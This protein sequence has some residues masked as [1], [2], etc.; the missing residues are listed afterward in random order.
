MAENKFSRIQLRRG[1]KANLKLINPM[2]KEGEP[3]SEI[4]TGRMKIGDGINRYN[5]LKYVGGG[6]GS[7]TPSIVSFT[8]TKATTNTGDVYNSSLIP[9]GCTI[10][11]LVL[12]YSISASPDNIKI[13]S[14]SEEYLNE[15]Y[16][17]NLTGN[18]TISDVD[19]S[20]DTTFKLTLVTDDTSVSANTI[21]NFTSYY[22]FT[23]I[24]SD[25]LPFLDTSRNDSDMTEYSK[26]LVS[27]RTLT[28]SNINCGANEYIYILLPTSI[29]GSISP[30]FTDTSNNFPGGF[31]KIGKLTTQIINKYGY[32]DTFD[33]YRSMNHTLG[34]KSFKIS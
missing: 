7:G 21:L 1:T 23:T 12:S 24:Q 26:K 14:Q 6:A 33:V 28:T 22:Y 19:I 29:Y 8:I 10:S 25:S 9:N 4:D 5:K 27:L 31:I 2:L 32:S 3:I 18:I 11:E 30:V 15:N 17:E 34:T 20:S 16:P 13:T